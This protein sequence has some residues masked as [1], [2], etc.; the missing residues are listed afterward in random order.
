MPSRRR[1]LI[2]LTCFGIIF[3]PGC[4]GSKQTLTDRVI[5]P[6]PPAAPRIEFVGIFSSDRELKITTE[7]DKHLEAFRGGS[8]YWKFSHPFGIAIDQ[9]DRVFVSDS[10]QRNIRIFDFEKRELSPFAANLEFSQ[11][12]GLAISRDGIVHVAD[13]GRG[14]IVALSAEGELLRFIGDNGQLAKPSFLALHDR[15]KRI[16]VADGPRHQVSVFSFEGEFLFSI[17]GQDDQKGKLLLPQGLCF[18]SNDRLYVAD[19]LNSRIQIFSTEGSPLG[20]FGF[21]GDEYWNLE[22]PRDIK[23]SPDNSL[24]VIDF[25]KALLQNYDLEGKLFFVL[26]NN[27][28]S[29]DVLGFATP[30]SL[31]IDSKQRIFIVDSLNRRLSVWQLLTDE[32]LKLRPLTADIIK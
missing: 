23:F 17:R 24:F 13:A 19:T 14:R 22:N 7:T 9:H 5:W 31:A 6:L 20:T 11:P 25:R 10:N 2:A 4:S 3:A 16:Y 15:L 30:T 32:Y 12:M 1:F 18:D 21:Q 29:K 28:R 8:H 27:R 26:G